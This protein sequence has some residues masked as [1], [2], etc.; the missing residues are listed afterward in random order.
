MVVMTPSDL[1]MLAVYEQ[2]AITHQ[3]DRNACAFYDARMR[4]MEA[5]LRP[6]GKTV[7]DVEAR[8]LT[9][10]RPFVTRAKFLLRFTVT[11]FL[12]CDLRHDW[13]ALNF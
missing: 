10:P 13:H 3:V 12:L 6:H 4:C 5:A 11:I 2:A 8:M 1:K 9:H 7:A